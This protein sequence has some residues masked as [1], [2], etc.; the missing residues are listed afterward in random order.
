[1]TATAHQ[2]RVIAAFREAFT[3]ASTVVGG[4]VY[5]SQDVKGLSDVAADAPLVAALHLCG[6]DETIQLGP[7]EHRFLAQ[8]CFK[9]LTFA[10]ALESGLGQAV[11]AAV[12]SI[13]DQPFGTFALAPDGRALNPLIN[14]GALVV[15]ELLSR[16][17]SEEEVGRWCRTLGGS[18]AHVGACFDDEAVAATLADSLRNQGLSSQLA[19]AGALPKTEDAVARAVRYYAALDCLQTD[20]VELARVAAAFAGGGERGDGGGDGRAPGSPAARTRTATLAAMLHGGMYEASGEWAA[21]VGLPAKSGVSG[22]VWCV[23]PGVGGL[24]AQQA[25]ID[26]AGNSVAAMALLRRMVAKLPELSVFHG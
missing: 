15:L 13:G 14:S 9:P 6:S 7:A 12:A 22:A 21:A 17:H 18:A 19:S 5:T 11:A 4:S 16:T 24:C 3:E 20:A 8:S 26:A 23:L 25:R 2:Q 10:M 1:M